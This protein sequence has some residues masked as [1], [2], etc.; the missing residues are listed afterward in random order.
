M[1]TLKILDARD[2]ERGKKKDH[3]M[4]TH[5]C[6]T[7]EQDSFLFLQ[8]FADGIRCGVLWTEWARKERRRK[9]HGTQEPGIVAANMKTTLL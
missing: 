9:K 4:A 3:M 7:L 6:I 1:R 5:I 2:N 8:C